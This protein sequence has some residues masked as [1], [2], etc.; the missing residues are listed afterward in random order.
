MGWVASHPEPSVGSARG[1]I[2]H[3]CSSRRSPRPTDSCS[4]MVSRPKWKLGR[5]RMRCRNRGGVW[6]RDSV[7]RLV[8]VD[9][10]VCGSVGSRAG[11]HCRSQARSPRVFSARPRRT[12]ATC[13]L[14]HLSEVADAE[15]PHTPR[16]CPFQAWS[17]GE[18]LRLDRQVLAESNHT[19]GV[20][21]TVRD[22]ELQRSAKSSST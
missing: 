19:T 6:E 2:T 14:G 9:G 22:G 11:E 13:G 7:N 18:F 1:G 5:L 20:S 4:S 15:P 8:V 3:C 10:A 12:S 17:L 21:G 16:G